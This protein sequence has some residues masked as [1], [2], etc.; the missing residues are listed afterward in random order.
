M[1]SIKKMMLSGALG[2]LISG[3]AYADGSSPQPVKPY[4]QDIQ[5]VAVN[6]EKP[7]SSFMSYADR[8]TALTSRFEKSPYYSLLNG[9]WK[10]FF[11]DSYKDLPQNITDPS[12]NT[13]SWDDITV[14]GNWEVQGHGVAIYTNHGYEFKPKNPQPPLLP[15]A[16]PV[17]VYRRDIE[18]PAGWDNR[19]IY[20][21]IGGA[22]SGLYVYLNGKEVGY[23][24]DSKNPAEFL[25]NKYLQPGKNV[26]TLKIFRWSTGSYL[27]CQD[28]WRMSG[29]ERDVFLWSQPK[30]SIQDFRIVSTL[31][32]TYTNGIFKLA[33]DLKNH[34]QETK[35]LNVGYELLDAKGNLMA[36]EANDI[37]VS[38]ASPQTASFEYDLKNVAPWSAEHP[39][40]YKLLMTIKEEGK[41]I[42]VVPFNVGFRRFEMKQI[43]QVAENGKPYTVLLFN[44]QP[45]KFKGVNIHEHNPETGHY[46]T[47]E[48]MRK[49]FELMKQNNINA[50]R[51]CHYPQDRKFYELCDEYG[52]YVYDEANIESH[53]MYYSLK[54][55]GTLGNNPEWLIP[56]MDR[57][58]N[59]YE[60]NKNYPSVTFW[61]LGNEA[62]NGY[63]FYQTYLY[64][65]DKEINSMNRPVN[66][67]RALWEWN[68]DM[69][70]PQY[71]SAEWLEEIGRKGSDRPVAPSEYSH[72][73]GNSSGN[74]WDQWKAIYK[75]PNLQGGFIWDWVDQGILEKDKNGRE[76]Y[77]YGG[78][79]GVN[80]PS[81]GNFLCNG[82]VNPD[83]TP[84]PAMAEVKYAHQN[85][86]FEAIDLANGLFRVTNRF[87]FT[88]LKKYMVH[89]NVTANNKVV[90]S[91]KVS[92]DIE[93]QAS[94]E[95]TVPVGNLKPQ[96]GTEYFV[97]FNVTT[98]EKEPLI[99]IGHE[100]ACDQFRL[101]IE[102]PKKAFKTSG[103]KLTVSTNGDN[104][105]A[106]SSKV[107]FM[108][109][110][111]TGIVT[112]YK[113]DGTEYFS[114]GFGIQPNF[115]RAPTDNDYGNGM[116]KRLQVWKESSKNFNVTDATAT[117]EGNNA[118]LNV[119]YL[120]PAGNLYIVNYTIYPSGAVN[121]AARFTSTDMDAAQT[122]VSE[123]TRTATFTPGRDAARKEASK[124]NVPRIGVRFRLPASMNQVE[125]FGRGPAENYL[126]RNA[127]SMVGLY[128]STAE[129]LYFPYV[130]PQENGHH[131]DT[132]WVS[133]STGKKGL[134]IQADNTIGF[135]ALR[136]SIE[137][138]DDEEATGLPRQWSNFTPEQ[139]ANHDEAAAK[140]VLRRQHHINDI[141]P[142]DFVEVCVDLKQ[143]GV[144]GYDSWGSRPEPAYTLPA[145][146]EYN[147]SFT[148]IPLK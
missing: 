77:T 76:Y 69:Y 70:V 120:L 102:S 127:G 26:L 126:D 117:M 113:V 141:T 60:R 125:Y 93:P 11:V 35:N 64:L 118:V 53:G 104:L 24:E 16:N 132:R 8:E 30:A 62:G 3:M 63:N 27:E 50:V 109:N 123:A 71:P 29:I 85:I 136:N 61:S 133:L 37:W 47:E 49:D 107:N 33:V 57:T 12:V 2:C 19:D 23:S 68:T 20:L 137:D 17:G 135:N 65:K 84:H 32:D 105:S 42:E 89:Y 111:K 119:N 46:V 7:R 59:M 72:A 58:M 115:W 101:P 80:A 28:F 100:I 139:V 92:L 54:K 130:R 121:V 110:K 51:L 95:F 90:R 114:E 134:L 131:T 75:Y 124:L 140:N 45:V 43:D 13:S 87:Y 147:W 18:I 81:D 122:E 25:I 74:L 97:N 145:N 55:G 41:V 83:R 98:V 22:K 86:G 31:D 4:W 142:R 128:K 1:N 34:T 15:E 40:L 67:E 10:F 36:S 94:K 82:I 5:V 144:A 48:L 39:N 56:H 38:S 9:T 21:H 143:Q 112:S 96:A 78:D 14:P 79:Y 129:E 66:Y 103:P 52:L 106:S 99:P 138:F 91:G 6:K 148:L 44:G 108:F 116:P 146:R 88:N 73:M